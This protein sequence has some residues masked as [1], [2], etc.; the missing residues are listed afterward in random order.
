MIVTNLND[1]CLKIVLANPSTKN[2]LNLA[3]IKEIT[4]VFLDASKNDDIRLIKLRAEGEHFCSGA[5]LLWMKE[6]IRLSEKENETQAKHLFD[7]FHAVFSCTKPVLT[8]VHGACFGGGLGLVAASDFVICANNAQFCLSEVKLGL[9]PATIS[10]FLIHKIGHGRFNALGIS[11]LLF[12]SKMAYDFGL[13]HE[14]CELF[15]LPHVEETRAK[16]FLSNGPMA[17]R[18]MKKLSLSHC[19][20]DFKKIKEQSAKSLAKIRTSKE[21]QEGLEA[22]LQKRKPNW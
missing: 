1:H 22:F 19:A 11:A 21:A 18:E 15:D 3:M 4:H 5:D 17:M 9:I 7:M 14:T 10:A 13:V 2:A 20:F 6:S 12:N 8:M 16:Q